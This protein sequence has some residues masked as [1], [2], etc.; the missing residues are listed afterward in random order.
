MYA[1][2]GGHEAAKTTSQKLKVFS[3]FS[4][5][6]K[7][8]KKKKVKK[9]KKKSKKETPASS[10]SDR[11]KLT[12]IHIYNGRQTIATIVILVN[13]SAQHF[14]GHVRRHLRQGA[15]GG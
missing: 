9:K 7:K 14:S 11:V 10:L 15:S 13:S 2:G 8:K 3:F 12:I 1:S 6:V 4:F 5:H